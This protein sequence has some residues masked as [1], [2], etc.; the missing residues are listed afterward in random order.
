[1]CHAGRHP[2]PGG[3]LSDVRRRFAVT[4]SLAVFAG[5][6]LLSAVAAP[7]LATASG[8]GSVVLSEFDNTGDWH[9]WRERRH[10]VDGDVAQDIWVPAR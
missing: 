8:P 2:V 6:M 1:M 7:S 9:L 4:A 5:A 10:V 3:V